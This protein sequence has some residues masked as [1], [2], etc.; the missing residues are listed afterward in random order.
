MSFNTSQNPNMWILQYDK[1][2]DKKLDS[3]FY[4]G[5]EQFCHDYRAV[6]WASEHLQQQMR[7]KNLGPA[8]WFEKMDN[9]VAQRKDLGVVLV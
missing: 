8:F 1:Y 2:K 9:F 6:M 5:F 3:L 7:N 4:T